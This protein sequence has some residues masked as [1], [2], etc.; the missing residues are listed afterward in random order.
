MKRKSAKVQ[1]G[2]KRIFHS[3]VTIG[4]GFVVQ[5]YVHLLYVRTFYGTHIRFP[6]HRA[7]ATIIPVDHRGNIP[8]CTF[9]F[10]VLVKHTP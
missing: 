10:M 5:S 4:T 1:L 8:I 6:I 2:L 7:H 9:L 3:R